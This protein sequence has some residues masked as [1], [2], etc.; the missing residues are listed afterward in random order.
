MTAGS[1][2]ATEPLQIDAEPDRASGVF[3]RARVRAAD[4]LRTWLDERG[5]RRAFVREPDPALAAIEAITAIPTPPGMQCQS[6]DPRAQADD[7]L[8]WFLDQGSPYISRYR[9]CA[10]GWLQLTLDFR[11]DLASKGGYR[12]CSNAGTRAACA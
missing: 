5:Y 7:D 9:P 12:V 6:T 11:D 1:T 4:R 8:T 3:E 10:D 2:L